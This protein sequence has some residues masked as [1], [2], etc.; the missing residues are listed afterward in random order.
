MARYEYRRCDISMH[1]DLHWL[2]MQ[3][4]EEL[5][6]TMN[7]FIVECIRKILRDTQEPFTDAPDLDRALGYRR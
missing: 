4:V 2:M 5:G 1:P 3:R 6:W 7:K